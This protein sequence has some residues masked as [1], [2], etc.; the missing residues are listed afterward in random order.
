MGQLNDVRF[1]LVPGGLGRLPASKDHVSAIIMSF[2][3]VASWHGA[4][5]KKYLSTEQAEADG[6]V[7]GDADYGLLWYFISEYFRIAGASEL[8]VIN[9]NEKFSEQAFYDITTGEVRQVF[10]YQE[11]LEYKNAVEEAGHKQAFADALDALYAP[12]VII[13]NITDKKEVSG[14]SQPDLRAADAKDV[15]ILIAGDGSGKGKEI[16]ESLGN[17]YIPAGGTVLGLLSK[18]KVHENI[19][20]PRKFPVTS[21]ADFQKIVFADGQY[22]DAKITSIKEILADKAYMFLRRLVGIAGNYVYD[23]YTAVDITSDYYSLENNRVI[24]KAKRQIR[25]HLLPDLMRPLYVDEEGKLAPDTVAYFKSTTS[26]PLDRM[27]ADGEISNYKVIVDPEQ[28]VLTT[29]KLVIDVK[30][31]PVGVARWITVNIG[32]TVKI[33]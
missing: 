24:Q 15:A 21:G 31:Q 8:Y 4:I 10:W 5:G 20:W 1:E 27:R 19:G 32:Y 11:N 16:A 13:M 30:I 22:E 7:D 18:A 2:K 14:G 6:I 25:K 17:K 29:S 33:K 26:T 12:L 9:E 3:D 28:D 23:T